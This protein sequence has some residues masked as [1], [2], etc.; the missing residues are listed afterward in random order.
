MSLI[1]TPGNFREAPH[2]PDP[3][4]PVPLCR[5]WK[6]Q[7]SKGQ[8]DLQPCLLSPSSN[9]RSGNTRFH[10]RFMS[11]FG[12]SGACMAGLSEV[13]S[14]VRSRVLDRSRSRSCQMV[15]NND[16]HS[17][18]GEEPIVVGSSMGL[19]QNSQ[20]AHALA[21]PQRVCSSWRFF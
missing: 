13:L 6:F 2:L 20:S 17:F 16:R 21:R 12:V 9:F 19:V 8:F 4:R 18:L 11:R 14:C 10:R 3:P 15:G 7:N 5:I 1:P